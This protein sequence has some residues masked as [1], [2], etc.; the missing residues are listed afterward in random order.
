MQNI[1]LSMGL[2]I[3]LASLSALVA[4]AIDMYLPAFP[5]MVSTLEI[6]EGQVQQ[7]L[8][9]FLIGLA[10]GQGFYG[11]LL[12]RFGRR[13]PLLAGLVLFSLGSVIA[14]LS[15]SFT[16][17][18]V[19]RFV[20]A[21]GAG[22]GSVASRAIVSDTSATQ[23]AARIYSILMQVMMI[24]PITAPLIGGMI[25]QLGAWQVI[26]WV[27]ALIGGLCWLATFRYLPETLSIE[28]RSHLGLLV[29]VQSYA[30]QLKQKNF[31]FYAFASGCTL[32][33]LF[34]YISISPFIFIEIFERTPTEFSY[35]FALNAGMMV[36]LSQLNLRLLKRFQAE[37][38][39]YIGLFSFTLAAI[40]LAIC[41]QFSLVQMWGYILLLALGVGSLGLITGNLTAVAMSHT[42]QHAGV[43]SALLGFI[44][45]TFAAITG[46]VGSLFMPSE[47]LL[48]ILF[49]G[50]GASA[51]VSSLYAGNKLSLAFIK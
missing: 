5:A 39:L 38:I 45:F 18:L 13:I 47:T 34:L 33:C 31:L 22:A 37:N 29:L 51:L 4:A 36:V 14:A 41:V 30:R 20:Q 7:T 25:L 6:T 9:I 15:T 35:I 21:L 27:L 23:E 16:F 3:L 10:I 50:L 32:G 42:V 12:D 24:A 28:K 49:I 46:F 40:L 48:P 26:F 44:Q 43:A 2:I 17:L 1:R 8:T 19:A 11:P